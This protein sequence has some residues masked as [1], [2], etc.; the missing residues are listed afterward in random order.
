MSQRISGNAP[1]E[2]WAS[3]YRTQGQF[4]QAVSDIAKTNYEPKM[5]MLKEEESEARNLAQ[6]REGGADKIYQEYQARGM[7]ALKQ[8]QDSMAQIIQMSGAQSGQAQQLLQSALTTG[9]PTGLGQ[10]GMAGQLATLA[11]GENAQL[12]ADLA[13]RQSAGI[14][15]I[16][17]DVAQVPLAGRTQMREN[18]QQNLQDSLSKLQSERGRVAE[19]IPND[20]SKARAELTKEEVN[21]AATRLQRELT[22][23]KIGQEGAI[24]TTEAGTRRAT[25]EGKREGEREKREAAAEANAAKRSAAE[26]KQ[27]HEKQILA[28]KAYAAARTW[29]TSYTKQ[30]K[31][32]F[33]PGL[34]AQARTEQIAKGGREY[35]RNAQQAYDALTSIYGMSDAQAL[36][37]LKSGG[38]YFK[39]FVED[40]EREKVVGRGVIRGA[41]GPRGSI[42]GSTQA[43]VGIKR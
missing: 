25:A 29:F 14:G 19:E 35:R 28:G 37:I 31:G 23:Q 40:R 32:E 38:G 5:G 13:R 6:Q 41:A 1:Y 33:S 43:G 10:S 16:A 36:N 17:Q 24:K 11:A 12:N 2:P 21:R 34:P 7:Q 30:N 15:E 26:W 4:N 8:A 39:S 18:E 22:Q 20:I 27:K 3:P 9:G 42:T